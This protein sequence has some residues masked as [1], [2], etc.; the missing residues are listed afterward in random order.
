MSKSI[1]PVIDALRLQE[2][3]HEMIRCANIENQ[4]VLAAAEKAYECKCKSIDE[5]YEQKVYEIAKTI[6]LDYF[7]LGS[8]KVLYSNILK[9]I[10]KK[11]DQRL[12]DNYFISLTH[13]IY[14]HIKDNPNYNEKVVSHVRR[15]WRC[16]KL[17]ST[18]EIQIVPREGE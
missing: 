6:Y 8:F 4:L 15:I 7:Q 3:Y 10:K 16:C 2:K 13:L 12:I 9:M 11:E 14:L 5:E 1:S 17:S 18:G